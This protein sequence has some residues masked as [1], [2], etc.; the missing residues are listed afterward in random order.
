MKASNHSVKVTVIT[1]VRNAIDTI[2]DCIVSV[3]EQDYDY[4]EH[5][6]VDGCS[7]DGTSEVVEKYR[8]NISKI[9]RERDHGIYD[10]LNKGI[11]AATGHIVGFLHADD[12]FYSND[13]IT[14]IVD[15]IRTHDVDSC[16]GD[17]VK[18][19]KKNSNKVV[20]CW[21]ADTYTP[22][23][24]SKGWMPP[25]P[26]FYARRAVYETYG[27]FNLDFT[28]A[29]D[30]EIL[31]RFL[32]KHGVSTSYIPATLTM[33]RLGG[34]SNKSLKNI[35]IKM[36][37]DYMAWRVNGMAGGIGVLMKKNLIKLPQFFKSGKQLDFNQNTRT[38]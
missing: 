7:N 9:I 10:A 13:V 4:I 11:L 27:L 1:A 31:I 24:F 2:E 25:H 12:L 6:I 37:E 22:G 30:Y 28:I 26:T 36:K 21:K 35:L 32:E 33:M 20:R 16:Y 5:I 18:K 38:K 17:L 14:K 29:A 34:A 23:Q 19:K 8:A 3:I 15:C